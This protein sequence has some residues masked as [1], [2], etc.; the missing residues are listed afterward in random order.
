MSLGGISVWPIGAAKGIYSRQKAEFAPHFGPSPKLVGVRMTR[1]S[2]F[3]APKKSAF[4]IRFARSS[5]AMLALFASQT[6]IAATVA[7]SAQV[8][9]PTGLEVHEWGTFTTLNSSAGKPLSGLY[10]DASRLPD[11]VHGLPYFNYDPLKGWATLDR[12]RNVTV[13]MGSREGSRPSGSCR[14]PWWIAS[15]PFP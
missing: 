11:F 6:A 4:S 5:A 7:P 1:P 3:A 8:E 10:V 2:R 9:A 14:G 12:L 15:C 13:K